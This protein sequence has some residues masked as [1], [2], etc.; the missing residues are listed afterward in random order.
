M[1]EVKEFQETEAITVKEYQ[2]SL[3]EGI[4]Q[5]LNK[6]QLSLGREHKVKNKSKK[7]LT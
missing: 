5:L 3:E 7:A 2:D 6:Y 4:Q 1:L